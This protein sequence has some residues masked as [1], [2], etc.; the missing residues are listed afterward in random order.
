MS[1]A[2]AIREVKTKIDKVYKVLEDAGATIPEDKNLDNLKLTIESKPGGE[3]V[4][5]YYNGTDIEEGKKVLLTNVGYQALS[6]GNFLPSPYKDSSGRAI[7]LNFITEDGYIVAERYASSG[8]KYARF[9]VVDGV[10][11][12]NSYADYSGVMVLAL[13]GMNIPMKNGKINV[14][15]KKTDMSFGNYDQYNIMT[16][17]VG[18]GYEFI[19]G[20]G[21]V[22][23]DDFYYNNRSYSNDKIYIPNDDATKVEV[24]I[25]TITGKTNGYIY[26]VGSNGVYYG[27]VSATDNQK[28]SSWNMIKFTGENGVY[29]TTPLGTISYQPNEVVAGSGGFA[30]GLKDSIK[31]GDY[32]LYFLLSKSRYLYFAIN[33][34]DETQCT[35]EVCEYPQSLKNVIGTRTINKV[36]TFYDGTFSFDL[37]EGTTLMCRFTDRYNIEVLEVVEPF[38]IEGDST[39]YHRNFT[40]SKMYWYLMGAP[41]LR[42]PAPYGRYDKVVASSNYLA[43]SP[44]EQRFNSTILTGFLTGESTVK[45]GRQLVEVKTVTK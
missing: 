6:D 33:E 4:M 9:N 20:R 35:F 26:I 23:L 29:T 30:I 40:C 15:M 24:D 1:I 7:Y 12:L 25:S 19:S 32:R 45:D 17:S 41:R 34:V 28:A 13:S 44:T 14:T 16:Y 31:V 27:A 43:V 36:Q 3:T 8:S 22:F 37:S 5:A 38:V 11:D 39:I 42:E 10:V 18:K 21:F 2:D